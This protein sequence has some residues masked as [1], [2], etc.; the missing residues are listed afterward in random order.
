MP[1]E[2]PITT[3]GDELIFYDFSN[4]DTTSHFEKPFLI[5]TK[6]G[7]LE[8]FSSETSD[9]PKWIRNFKRNIVTIYQSH[10]VNNSWILAESDLGVVHSEKTIYGNC[11][12]QSYVKNY[13]ESGDYI[14]KTNFD[15]KTCTDYK[16]LD[17]SSVE[18]SHCASKMPNDNQLSHSAERSYYFSAKSDY[19]LNK[20]NSISRVLYYPFRSGGKQFYS[21]VNQTFLHD[22]WDQVDVDHAQSIDSFVYK[23]SLILDGVNSEREIIESVAYNFYPFLPDTLGTRTEI[24]VS[25]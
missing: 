3:F 12:M 2:G 19:M 17:I 11:Q 16:I 5:I 14:F 13:P 24:C 20:I 8:K 15:A 23:W 4:N 21:V 9:E 22:S 7:V 6:N 18:K 1:R 10:G 25:I